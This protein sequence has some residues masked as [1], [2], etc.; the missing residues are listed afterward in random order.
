VPVRDFEP[1]PDHGF[2]LTGRPIPNAPPAPPPAPNPD[3]VKSGDKIAADLIN[4]LEDCVA[5][6]TWKN[7]GGSLATID[8]ANGQ[9]VVYQTRTNQDL[10]GRILAQLRE[11]RSIQ[12]SVEARFLKGDAVTKKV[13]E[14]IGSHDPKAPE[15]T[16]LDETQTADLLQLAKSDQASSTISA[17]RLTLFNGQRAYVTVSTS[18]AYVAS[19]T[20]VIADGAKGF[21]PEIRTIESGIILDCQA[22][23]AANRKSVT[24]TLRPQVANLLSLEKKQVPEVRADPND[25]VGFIQVPNVELVKFESTVQIPE[26]KTLGALLRPQTTDGKEGK[27][28]VLLVTPAL[29]T[30]PQQPPP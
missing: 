28:V 21:D 26:K 22:T 2:T 1:G 19:L 6:D 27:A 3:D 11:G 23:A 8:E 29:I 4:L 10:V 20:P 12:I 14:W 7:R 30:Q 9:L 13:A 17:P 5:P 24:L 16:Y 18:R 15:M 25:Q